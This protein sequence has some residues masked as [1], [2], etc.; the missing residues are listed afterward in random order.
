MTL[1]VIVPPVKE[2]VGIWEGETDAE[3][4]REEIGE[5]EVRDEPVGKAPVRVK[6]GDG[7]GLALLRGLP[8]GVLEEL[9]EEESEGD[10]EVLMEVFTVGEDVVE[11]DSVVEELVLG[12]PWTERVGEFEVRD[13]C[14][15]VGIEDALPLL[16]PK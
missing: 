12:V 10:P 16:E 14:V 5:G 11:P 15:S 8:E 6:S 13:V 7:V 9:T 4:V 1:G 2:G 3:A